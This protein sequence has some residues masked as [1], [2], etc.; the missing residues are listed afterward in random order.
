MISVNN[1][2][3]TLSV[4]RKIL[5]GEEKMDEKIIE[6][7]KQGCNF[8]YGKDGYPLDYQRAYILINEAAKGGLSDAMN[9]LGVMYRDGND[10]CQDYGQA[11]NW[12]ENALSADNRN[13]LAYHNIGKMYYNGLG[14][15]KSIEKAYEYFG[16][17]IRFNP[18]KNGS[19]YVDDCFTVGCIFISRNRLRE[20]FPYFKEAAMKGNKP[21][22]WHNLGYICSKKGVP[23]ADRQTSFP[24][25]M[26]AA[27]LGYVPSM[28]EIG[29][30]YISKM[31]FSEG[32][33]WVEKAAAM[34]Y[35]PAIKNI[36][37][38]KAG[39]AAHNNSILDYF[40]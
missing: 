25:F 40:G 33:P 22:A 24:Y 3:F 34:G 37:K 8:Y 4:N 28:Y 32:M 15:S 18:S 20:A 7:Y 21:E 38:F 19:I 16:N 2:I 39:R 12:F 6:T 14:V 5:K 10:V 36:K 23:G 11:F 31:M 35:E 1:T 27:N 26:K 17:A 30:I 9:H 13:Y 29:C